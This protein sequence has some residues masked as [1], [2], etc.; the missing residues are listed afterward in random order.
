[1]GAYTCSK[2]GAKAQSEQPIEDLYLHMRLAH[3]ETYA[4]APP[5]RK[6]GTFVQVLPPTPGR[7]TP[8]G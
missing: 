1:M 4:S 6:A 3:G 2:C 8:R 5:Q 7:R